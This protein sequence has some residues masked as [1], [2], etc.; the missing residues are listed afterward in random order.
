MK[1]VKRFFKALFNYVMLMLG[2]D[3]K[4]RRDAVEGG[5]LDLSGQGRGK[6]GN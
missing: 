1:S 5:V 2:L 4:A 3:C 6:H